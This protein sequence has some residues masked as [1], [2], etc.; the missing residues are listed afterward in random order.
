MIEISVYLNSN[1]YAKRVRCFSQRVGL[2]GVD[3]PY[4]QL[5]TT[6][7]FMFG[8]SAIVEFIIL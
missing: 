7:R 5:L 8:Q 3:V 2:V 4:T 1:A 6:L